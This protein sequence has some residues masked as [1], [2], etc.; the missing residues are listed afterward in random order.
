MKN[1]HKA[2]MCLF[3]YR[4]LVFH[5]K[6]L[7]GTGWHNLT[8]YKFRFACSFD[9]L[10]LGGALPESLWGA[11]LQVLYRQYRAVFHISS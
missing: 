4:I 8:R 10:R 9:T 11:D 6:F 3:I 2:F 7:C 1:F 5:M